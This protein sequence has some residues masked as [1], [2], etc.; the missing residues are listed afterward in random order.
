MVLFYFILFTTS[1][2]YFFLVI[3]TSSEPI[4]TQELEPQQ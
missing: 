1:Y 4:T 2:P 3:Y